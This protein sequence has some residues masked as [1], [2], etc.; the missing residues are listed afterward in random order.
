[1]FMDSTFEEARSTPIK[2]YII[3]TLKLCKWLAILTVVDFLR[4]F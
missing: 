1:M 2:R 4:H 3:T